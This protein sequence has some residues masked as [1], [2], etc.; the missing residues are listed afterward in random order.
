MGMEGKNFGEF[1]LTVVVYDEDRVKVEHAVAEFQKLF[2]QHDG[3]LYEERYNLLNAFFA[4][5]PGNKQFNLRRQWALNSNYADLSFLFTVDVGAQWNPHLEREYLAVLESTHGTPYYLNMHCGDVAHGLMLGATGSGKSFCTGF[6]LQSVQKYDPLTFI[7]DLGGSYETVTRVFGGTYLNVGMKRPGF[8]INPFLLAPTH[9]T[10]NFLYLF[11]RVLIEAGG[12]YELTPEDEKALFAAIERAYSVYSF[13][14][15]DVESGDPDLK[16]VIEPSD[17]S[18]L[19]A[20][21]GVNRLVPA[22]EVDAAR[23]QALATQ[24]RAADAIEQFRAEYPVKALKF[25][26]TYHNESPFDVSAIYHDDKFTFIKSSAAEKFSIYE[27]KDGKPDLI[28]F[29]LQDSTYI[30]PTVVDKGYLQIGKH[31]LDFAR[32][33]Q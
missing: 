6:M 30:I 11:L 29:Q 3:L 15:D 9:E 26:Y 1:T 7:F 25:D 5:V 31:K 28:T 17:P 2:T 33:A 16:V 19:A 18:S 4:T 14:L 27:L 10:I 32:K 13:T 8:V 12:R 24:N 20:A 22:N 23:A 21:S